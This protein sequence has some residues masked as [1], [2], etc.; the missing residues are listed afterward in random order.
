MNNTSFAGLDVSLI[1]PQTRIYDMVYAPME[2][3]LLAEAK[4]RGLKYANGLGMLAAQGEAA[5]AL[6]TGCEPPSG[7]MKNCLL[8]AVAVK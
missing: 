6:W 7:I 1:K 4:A 8:A 2:T 5:F 3:P